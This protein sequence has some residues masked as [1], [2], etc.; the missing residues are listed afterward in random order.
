M[1]L[2][3]ERKILTKFNFANHNKN[4]FAKKNRNTKF[5]QLMSTYR[6][7]TQFY[8]SKDKYEKIEFLKIVL[9]H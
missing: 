8:K 7:S 3:N 6:K 1:I 4:S 2:S 9:M 5:W